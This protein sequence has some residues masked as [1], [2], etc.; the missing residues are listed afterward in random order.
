MSEVSYVMASRVVNVSVCL[1]S[2]DLK[3][4]HSTIGADVLWMCGRLDGKKKKKSLSGL[5]F[6]SSTI[7]GSG[8]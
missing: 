3:V 8:H 2:S 5:H 6:L 1:V 4:M 7:G